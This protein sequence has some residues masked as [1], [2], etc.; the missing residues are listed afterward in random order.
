MPLR[1]KTD[2]WNK[3]NHW[4]KTSENTWSSIPQIY[5]KTTSPT[6]KWKPLYKYSWGSW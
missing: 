3:C 4:V 1:L 6:N 5:V 2:K